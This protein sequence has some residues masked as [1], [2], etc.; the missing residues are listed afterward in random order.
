MSELTVDPVRAW[1]DPQYR[2]S[3]APAERAAVG[4]P[5]PPVDLNDPALAD[6]SVGAEK[7][8][9]GCSIG[10]TCNPFVPQCNL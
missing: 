3:L 9:T 4:S 5:V 7:T 1:K 10:G 8:G 6:L 2:A